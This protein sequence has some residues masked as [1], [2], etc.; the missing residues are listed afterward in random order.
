MIIR[1]ATRL[2]ELKE[3]YFSVKLKEVR[4]LQEAGKKVINLGI[5]S[6]DLAPS[7]Q[8][9]QALVDTA[10]QENSHG[11]QPYKG[12]GPMR[13]AMASWYES[14]YGVTLNPETEI[15]PLMGSKEGITHISLAFLDPG[16]EVLIPELG[17]PSYKSVSEMVGAVVRTYPLR[18]EEG[19]Q[20]DWKAME[21]EDYRKVKLMWINYP[22]MPTGAPAT[23]E[24]FEKAVAFAQKHQILLC[25]DN[26]YS[27]ILND[28]PPISLLSVEGAKEVC[29]EMN[30]M[31]KS[32]NM[33][34]WRVGWI[35]GAQEYIDA[36]LKVKSNVDSGM[37]LGLQQAAVKALEN[38]LEWHEAQNQIYRRRRAFA[39]KIVQALNCRFNPGQV[40]MFVWAKVPDSLRSVEKLVDYLLYQKH[41]FLTPGFIFGKK[42]ERY[43]RISLC[44]QEEQLE[45]A[46]ER[47]E[48]ID[49]TGI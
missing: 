12:I 15:L 2:N 5:G 48:N 4:A 28:E 21:Q 23:K 32:H 20:P 26:P 22:H 42:G 8:T 29:L 44:T 37:F 36:I 27:L 10:R 24:L 43:I 34:G 33:A 47:L 19:W 18:E 39:E 6:P 45:E 41:I 11:Y 31:S 40:G 16:D 1:T 3:Y 30:S 46:L 14:T 35:S 9:V 49:I 25:H 38:P 17:Y 13:K 7:A